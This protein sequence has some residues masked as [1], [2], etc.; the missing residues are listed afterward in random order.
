[1]DS[2]GLRRFY[3]RPFVFKLTMNKNV[4]ICRD[5]FNNVVQS[6][7]AIG[8]NNHFYRR[9]LNV[10]RSRLVLHLQFV[11]WQRSSQYWTFSISFQFWLDTKTLENMVQVEKY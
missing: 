7:F 9:T 2:V 6:K 5:P 3:K 4:Y 10:L 1:M 11:S 8:K